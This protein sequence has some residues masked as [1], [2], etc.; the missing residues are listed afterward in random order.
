MFVISANHVLLV[1][2]QLGTKVGSGGSTGYQYL[3]ATVR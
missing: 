3:R 1:Q 2:R